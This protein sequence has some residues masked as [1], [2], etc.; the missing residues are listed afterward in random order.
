MSGILKAAAPLPF[1]SE[2]VTLQCPAQ[3]LDRPGVEALFPA[4]TGVHLL[5]ARALTGSP[6]LQA[7]SES[8]TVAVLHGGLLAKPVGLAAVF[9]ATLELVR[10]FVPVPCVCG[11]V[12]LAMHA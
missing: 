2:L 9:A 6:S 8:L 11:C 1:L 7:P 12:F 3:P 10:P 4:A 5:P